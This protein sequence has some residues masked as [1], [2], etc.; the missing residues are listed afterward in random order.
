MDRRVAALLAALGAAYL[1]VNLNEYPLFLGD[2]PGPGYFPL[3][4]GVAIILAALLLLLRPGV[5]RENSSF[6]RADALSILRIIVPG[7]IWLALLA[8]TGYFIATAVF[9]ALLVKVLG[10]EGWLKPAV[11]S[12]SVAALS[13]WLFINLLGVPF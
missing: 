10:V 13:Q 5:A 3:V 1:A 4:V 9:L 6:G 11:F 12:L 8:H 2:K 7:C